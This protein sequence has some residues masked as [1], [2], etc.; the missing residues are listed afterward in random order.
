MQWSRAGAVCLQVMEELREMGKE[1]EG[2]KFCKFSFS[3]TLTC[4]FAFNFAFLPFLSNSLPYKKWK[5]Q[6]SSF[7]EVIIKQS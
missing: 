5:I 3:I 2:G 4:C 1:S 6:H 7:S